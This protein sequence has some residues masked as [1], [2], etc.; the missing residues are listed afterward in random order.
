MWIIRLPRSNKLEKTIFYNRD[1]KSTAIT[2]PLKRG[3]ALLHRSAATSTS[4]HSGQRLICSTDTAMNACFTKAHGLS[5]GQN[6]SCVQTLCSSI[7]HTPRLP[8]ALLSFN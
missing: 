6:T 8:P 1:K 3:T 7:E 2:V 5:A 4:Y